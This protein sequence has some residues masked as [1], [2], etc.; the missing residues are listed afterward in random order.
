MDHITLKWGTLKSWKLSSDKGKDLLRK[1]IEI[2]ASMSAMLQ[3]DTPEQKK[4]ICEMID[5]CDAS[6]IYLDWDDE[7]V[8]KEAA[9]KYVEEYGN[10]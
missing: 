6:E 9:K 2:G 8:S 5:E 10:R 7:W 3:R 1:Y 4:L